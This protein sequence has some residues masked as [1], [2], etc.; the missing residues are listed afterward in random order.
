M[1]AQGDWKG[2]QEVVLRFGGLCGGGK[3][4]I[5]QR[6]YSVND[7]AIHSSTSR[8]CT[9]SKWHDIVSFAHMILSSAMNF[10][11]RLLEEIVSKILY[12][13][14]NNREATKYHKIRKRAYTED[15]ASPSF[16]RAL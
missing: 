8:N 4:E 15:S 14:T 3:R 7:F 5:F 16:R 9:I 10:F 1:S 11:P 6:Y 2:H 12:L 13:V